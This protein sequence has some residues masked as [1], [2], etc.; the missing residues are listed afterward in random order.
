MRMKRW[1]L[2]AIVALAAF[3]TLGGC[4][5]VAPRIYLLGY[6][7]AVTPV[8]RDETGLAMIEV[9]PVSVP[10]FQDSRDIFVRKGP[11]ELVADPSARW[12][13]RLSVGVSRAL[14]AALAKRQPDIRVTSSRPVLPAAQ[15]VRVDVDT[16]EI[17][18]D[19]LCILGA[20]WSITRDGNR[21]AA[22]TDYAR[23][24]VNANGTD[25]ADVVGAMTQ[26]IDQ[27]ADHISVALNHN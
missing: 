25:T 13:E 26:A 10:D 21:H 1:R 23:F 12:G 4:A 14:I 3:M 19:G 7:S 18:E 5:T 27:L 20:R 11:N 6:P 15:Q 2:S 16:F 9:E 17:R 8:A 22:T 24:T